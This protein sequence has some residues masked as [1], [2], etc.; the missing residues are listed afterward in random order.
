MSMEPRTPKRPVHI[1]LSGKHKKLRMILICILLAVGVTA[2]AFGLYTLIKPD[3]GWQKVEANCDG[4]NVGQDFVLQYDYSGTSAER[5]QLTSLYSQALEDAYWIFT[6][7]QAAEGFANLY[8]LNHSP[9]EK[10]T[11]DPALYEALFLLENAGSRQ[12]YLG[13]V[14]R[15][16]YNLFTSETDEQAQTHDPKINGDATQYIKTLITFIQSTDA[17]RLELLG[18][19]Q[20]ILHISDAYLN[21]LRQ[22]EIDTLLDFH[23][24]KN[25]FIADYLAE[26]LKSQGFTSGYLASYDGFTRNLYGKGKSF[27][28]NIYDYLDNTIYPAGVME[29]QGPMSIVNLRGFPI[30]Q[31]DRYHYYAYQ[32]GQLVTPYIDP[33]DGLCKNSVAS[34]ISYSETKSCA[35][36][37]LEIL[38]VYISGTFRQENL[39]NLNGIE[40]VWCQDKTIFRTDPNLFIGNLL[41]NEEISYKLS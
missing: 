22:N 2:L 37:L 6:S 24:M 5:R 35:R 20:V 31:E 40:S 11:V 36:I 29:Y 7:D 13:P 12:L 16:Y 33:A 3:T 18:N 19:N 34:L 23:F 17:I 21:F 4:I 25:A 38:P 1:E 10:L 9:N 30:M 41:T 32:T 14:Y 8:T 15:E 27:A 26:T 28:L 39:L